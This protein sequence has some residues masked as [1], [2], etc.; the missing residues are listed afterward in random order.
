VVFLSFHPLLCSDMD[1]PLP[2]L[3]K[4]G[5]AASADEENP[6]H[7]D[8]ASK[9]V[10]EEASRRP[11]PF[12]RLHRRAGQRFGYYLAETKHRFVVIDNLRELAGLCAMFVTVSVAILSLLIGRAFDQWALFVLA[13]LLLLVNGVWTWFMVRVNTTFDRR[14]Q[15]MVKETTHGLCRTYRAG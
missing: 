7:P 2:P 5:G 14:T 11:E 4:I 8:D 9:D 12:H 6:L 3:P 15:R 13:A 1:R 10:T